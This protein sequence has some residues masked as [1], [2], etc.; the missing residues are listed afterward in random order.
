M[1]VSDFIYLILIIITTVDTARKLITR[2]QL[3][4]KINKLT[5]CDICF[6]TS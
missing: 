5:T 6:F 4:R 3:N 2:L 1:Y